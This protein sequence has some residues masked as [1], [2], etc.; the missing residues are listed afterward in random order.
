MKRTLVALV[1]PGL[2]GVAISQPSVTLYGIADAGVGQ[3][4]NGAPAR[5]YH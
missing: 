5:D 3:I 1:M 2:S 4:Q